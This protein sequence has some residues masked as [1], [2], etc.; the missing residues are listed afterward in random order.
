M[1]MKISVRGLDDLG[2]FLKHE[3]EPSNETL[4]H[5]R[6]LAEQLYE[7]CRKWA[8]A[9]I[10]TC[11]A[12][13]RR[14]EREGPGGAED[15]ILALYDDFQKINYDSL[16]SESP[17]VKYLLKDAQFEPFANACVDFYKSAL[18]VKRIVYGEIQDSRGNFAR[19]PTASIQKMFRLWRAEVRQMF[20]KVNNEWMKV[21]TIQPVPPE[22]P[23][24]LESQKKKFSNKKS[25]A[26]II[27]VAALI[28][29]IA[30]VTD[31]IK[32]ISEFFNWDI[33]QSP[34]PDKKESP[35]PVT[36]EEWWRTKNKGEN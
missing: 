28:V 19:Y 32:K 35:S 30:E 22:T 34:N 5:R 11:E 3:I 1:I 15:E 25:I 9:L 27:L 6:Q 29:G 18:N 16:K 33:I 13:S 36:F 23:S 31:A 24:Y 17:I 26:L 8:A 4:E 2:N 7:Y 14:W 20:Q 12:V 10:E 21:Q